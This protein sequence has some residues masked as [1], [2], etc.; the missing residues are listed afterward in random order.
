MA[1]SGMTFIIADFEQVE[2]R[3]LCALAGQQ[4]KIDALASGRDL[5]C[6]FS[7]RLYGREITRANPVERNVGKVGV[8]SCGYGSGAP[9]IQGMC[10]GKGLFISMDEAQKMYNLYRETHPKVVSF[11]RQCDTAIHILARGESGDIGPIHIADHDLILPN[12]LRMHYDLTRHDDTWR[13]S[14]TRKSQTSDRNLW[15][16]TLAE[17]TASSLARVLLSDAVI[18]VKRELG[19]RPALLVHDDACYVIPEADAEDL[20]QKII[21]IMSRTPVWWPNGPS[22]SADGR[23]DD[24]YG[25]SA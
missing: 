10:W 5:Y 19:L 6:E 21:S 11:W 4:D 22:I 15:G 8:L 12:G 16:G 24:R 9:K 25:K 7:A 2:Y 17:N 3:V 23:I 20:Y 18:A 14:W 1:S 13:L